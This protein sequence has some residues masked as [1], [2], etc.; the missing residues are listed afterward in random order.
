MFPQDKAENFIL[1]IVASLR[2]HP[3]HPQIISPREVRRIWGRD[4]GRKRF[5]LHYVDKANQAYGDV[6]R[7][8]WAVG[9]HFRIDYYFSR[10][11]GDY[12]LISRTQEIGL[13]SSCIFRLHEERF[14]KGVFTC[15]PEGNPLFTKS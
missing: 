8:I 6:C 13:H 10:R 9:G 4:E 2:H 15:D 12:E 5:A 11:E 3:K 7:R 14:E 1:N